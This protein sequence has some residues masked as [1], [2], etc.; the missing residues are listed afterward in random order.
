MHPEGILE[1]HG[2]VPLDQFWPSGTADAD[3]FQVVIGDSAFRWR[4]RPGA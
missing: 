1:L 2:V 4:A 3:T